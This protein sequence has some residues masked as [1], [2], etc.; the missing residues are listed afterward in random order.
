MARGV[1]AFDSYKAAAPFQQKSLDAG[2]GASIYVVGFDARDGLVAEDDILPRVVVGEEF[3]AGFGIHV[4]SSGASGRKLLDGLAILHQ[5]YV[6]ERLVELARQHDAGVVGYV[7]QSGAFPVDVTRRVVLDDGAFDWSDGTP[8]GA[9][10]SKSGAQL[11]KGGVAVRRNCL[12]RYACLGGWALWGKDAPETLFVDTDFHEEC[13]DTP[14]WVKIDIDR[15]ELAGINNEFISLF[16]GVIRLA[17]IGGHN[18][19]GRF[20]YAGDFASRGSGNLYIAESAGALLLSCAYNALIE[21]LFSR[22]MA[23]A[24]SELNEDLIDLAAKGEW[25]HKEQR[26]LVR[27]LEEIRGTISGSVIIKL[28]KGSVSVMSAVSR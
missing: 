25:R 20:P 8:G 16:E 26:R 7:G 13:P 21:R 11:E 24:F 23:R 15:G 27:E 6:G 2:E 12:V 19:V 5:V 4:L 1:Y 18:G 9:S 14:E 17:E 28:Y 3:S 10:P 22:R